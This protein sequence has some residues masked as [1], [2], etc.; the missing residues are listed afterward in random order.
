VVR[1]SHGA[2][3]T[4]VSTT[5]H[6]TVPAVEIARAREGLA[7]LFPSKAEREPFL[8]WGKNLFLVEW[9]RHHSFRSVPRDLIPQPLEGTED[10]RSW[11]VWHVIGGDRP[12][13]EEDLL[14]LPELF[15]SAFPGEAERKAALDWA[16]GFYARAADDYRGFQKFVRQRDEWKKA[17]GYTTTT[18]EVE[19]SL[20]TALDGALPPDSEWTLLWLLYRY[21][22]LNEASR[23]AARDHWL[24]MFPAGAEQD[25]LA[26]GREL[27]EERRAG[28]EPLPPEGESLP[29]LCVV[30]RL[31]W[32]DGHGLRCWDCIQEVTGLDTWST[33][34]LHFGILMCYP[35]DDSYFLV[36]T[37]D[38]LGMFPM[39]NTGTWFNRAERVLGQSVFPLLGSIGVATFLSWIVAPL[40]LRGTAREMWKQ[41]R[42]GR[43]SEPIWVWLISVCLFGTLGAILAPYTLPT[44]I[45]IQVDT[46]PELLVGSLVA[47]A[48]GGVL[49]GTCRRILAVLLTLFRVDVERTWLDEIIGILLGG[50]ILLF[51]GNSIIAI[52]IFALAD[53]LPG[54]IYSRLYRRDE[55]PIP[56]AV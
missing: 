24:G 1:F 14:R 36:A 42:E 28:D 10:E 53:L 38:R 39:G 30:E 11:I 44:A 8:D 51:F 55:V 48:V 12:G 50:W 49:I 29:L 9:I 26:W 35:N 32:S 5:P 34:S 37:H 7:R 15:Q 40:L 13:V 18:S 56:A 19:E 47:T 6:M 33:M 41:H 4:V 52:A 23:A 22:G 43:G 54:L 46:F 27:A 45:G 31:T 25:V 17:N 2:P 20:C 21:V 16:R 3:R